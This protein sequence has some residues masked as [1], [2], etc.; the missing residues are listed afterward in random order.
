MK[1]FTKEEIL[2]LKDKYLGK[3]STGWK[4]DPKTGAIIVYGINAV[5]LDGK[6]YSLENGEVIKYPNYVSSLRKYIGNAPLQVPGTGV[7]VYRKNNQGKIEILLQL[8]VDCN[9]YGLP[10]GAIEL[11]ETYQECAANELQQETGLKVE[12]S[13]FKL[14]DVFAGAKHITRYEDTQDIVYH[15]V[16]VYMVEYEKC[17]KTNS[18]IDKSETKELKWATISE[19]QE[20]LNEKKV[21]PNNVPILGDIIEFLKNSN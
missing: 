15:T 17:H 13:E 3:E 5:Y 4:E 9:K 11:G 21:F 18:T 7:V 8:R 19:I 12:P 1:Y 2:K 20:F 14:F 10:G 16:V 6:Y